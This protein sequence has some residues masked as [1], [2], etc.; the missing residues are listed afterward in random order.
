L[1][2]SKNGL[3]YGL[4]DKDTKNL[5]EAILNTN[6]CVSKYLELNKNDIVLDAGC[7]TGNTSIFISESIGAKIYGI[8]L[9]KTQIKI[10][11]KK[12]SKSKYS[13]LQEF[14]IM[15]FTKTRFKG[16]FFSKIYGIE[17][18]CHACKKIDF[19]NEGFRVLKKG[20]KIAIIDAF[21]TRSN[22]NEKEKKI[23]EAFRNGYALS[24][25][26]TKDGFYCDLKKAGFKNIKFHDKSEMVKRSSDRIY[27]LGILAY[28]LTLILSGTKLIP[29]DLYRN[30]LAAVNQKK[31]VDNKMVAY[32]IFVAEK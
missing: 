11:R 14:Y 12:S 28:P 9:S 19:L 17:S 13:H 32:G 22:F 2:W 20:G 24:N 26:S 29:K 31:L 10:A 6:I 16:E 1:F 25:L 23:Y 5:T 27:R 4:W 21:L 7:G 8:T 3:H 15:D 30:I 18:I